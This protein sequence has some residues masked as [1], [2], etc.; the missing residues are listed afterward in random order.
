[1][2]KIVTQREAVARGAKAGGKLLEPP[3]PPAAP[4]PTTEQVIAEALAGIR[5]AVERPMPAAGDDSALRDLTLELAKQTALL[6]ELCAENTGH[7]AN[8]YPYVF[9]IQRD[10]NGFIKQVVVTTQKPVTH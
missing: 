5:A 2:P 6:T 7:V 9:D 3:K 4:K 8:E 1:M 10:G